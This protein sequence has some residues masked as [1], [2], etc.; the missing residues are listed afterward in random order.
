MEEIEQVSD[1]AKY[2]VQWA[3]EVIDAVGAHRSPKFPRMPPKRY[4]NLLPEDA[5]VRKDV[6]RDTFEPGD[7][8]PGP[9]CFRS[10][11]VDTLLRRYSG[12]THS[13]FVDF[14]ERVEKMA[15]SIDENEHWVKD[16]LSDEELMALHSFVHDALEK[17]ASRNEWYENIEEW[18]DSD[19]LLA[20]RIFIALSYVLSWQKYTRC[21]L[22]LCTMASPW[23]CQLSDTIADAL[24]S[25]SLLKIHTELFCAKR[26][27]NHFELL[28]HGYGENAGSMD[29]FSDISEDTQDES[30]FE[31][32]DYDEDDEDD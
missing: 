12:S 30:A 8:S 17:L 27:Y 22:F 2:I 16:P 26:R 4:M 28:I 13:E 32:G 24:D 3:E 10:L 20:Q 21:V 23:V 14:A 29:A 1:E 15:L 6:L 11:V 19:K 7:F 18:S 5:V 25:P 9:M 31:M